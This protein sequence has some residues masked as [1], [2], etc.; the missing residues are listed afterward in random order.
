MGYLNK[1]F[2]KEDTEIF[3]RVRNKDL[4]A[5]LLKHLSIKAISNVQLTIKCQ[6][7]VETSYY[8]VSA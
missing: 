5:K 1:G 7:V 4:K 8:G 6:G 2:W 3:I